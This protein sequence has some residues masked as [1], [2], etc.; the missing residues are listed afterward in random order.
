M[1]SGRFVSGS[2]AKDLGLA[3][4]IVPSDLVLER[5]MAMAHGFAQG[6]TLSLSMMKRQFDAA[7]AQNLDQALDFEANIQPLM[8]MT[9]DF[10]E[11]SNSFKEKRKPVFKGA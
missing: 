2:E 6:P 7:P 3:I 8:T 11:G 10:R 1:Y 9:E 5:A 4:E